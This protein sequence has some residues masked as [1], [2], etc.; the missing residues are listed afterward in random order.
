MRLKLLV[1]IPVVFILGISSILHAQSAATG[2]PYF[3]QGVHY[4]LD[5]TFED[6]YSSPA[7]SGQGRL[8]YT[9]NS[10]DT[11]HEL[12]FHLYWNLFRSGSY[13]ERAPNRDHSP[14]SKYGRGGIDIKALTVGDGG[15]DSRPV[16]YE[17]DNTIMR[18]FL[19]DPLMPGA[20]R[21]IGFEWHAIFPNY[22]VRSTWGWHDKG[23]RNFATAQWYPQV[24]VY[25]NHGWHPDQYIGMGEFYTD[26]G[27]FDVS[28]KMPERFST[29]VS[30]GFQTNAKDILPDSVNQHLDFAHAHP[31][32]IVHISDR[33][34]FQNTPIKKGEPTRTWKFHADSVRDFAWCADEAYIWDAVFDGGVMHHA[35]YWNSSHE[36]WSK[37]AAKIVLVTE[38]TNSEFAGKYAYPNMFLCE[39]YEGGMEYPGIVFVGPS[40]NESTYHWQHNTMMHELGHEWYPMMMG[41]NETDY[42]Y[43]DEG[44]NTFI[45]T[46]VQ[47]KYFGR[48][49]NSF[50]P[51]LG[52]NDDERTAN[53]RNA[54]MHQLI[55][56]QEPSEQKAD[57]YLSYRDY[58]E[59]TYP[60]TSSVFFMLRYTMGEKAFDDFMHLYYQRWRFKHPYPDDLL[61]AAEDIERTEGDT[62]R[63][64]ARGDLRWFFDEWFNK[65]WKLDYAVEDFHVSDTLMVV[66]S[67]GDPVIPIMQTV[68]IAKVTIARK[69]R[70]VMP[71]DLV[72]TFDDG[73]TEQRWIPVDDWLR[74][75]ADERT[76]TYTFAKHPTRVEINPSRELKE[77]NR[78]NNT[79]SWLPPMEVGLIPKVFGDVKPIDKYAIRSAPYVWPLSG[80]FSSG[81]LLGWTFL[82]SYLDRTDRIAIGP[83]VSLNHFDHI[84]NGAAL[85]YHTVLD[86]LSPQTDLDL[87][88]AP[89]DYPQK[90]GFQY[91]GFQ[92]SYLVNRPGTTEPIDIFEGG[93]DVSGAHLI[94]QDVIALPPLNRGHVGYSVSAS[95]PT[96][97]VTIAAQFEDGLGDPRNTYTKIAGLLIDRQRITSDWSALA[98]LFGGSEQ[99]AGGSIPAQT[100]FQLA[101]PSDLDHFTDLYGSNFGSGVRDKIRNATVS[102]PL[103]R[104]Y[105]GRGNDIG[106]AA[107]SGT[108]EIS[109]YSMFPFSLLREI[110]IVGNIFKPFGLVLFADAGV[111]SN[112]VNANNLHDELKSDLGI[113]L[114]WEGL[115]GRM[116]RALDID[117]E[118]A[119]FQID[120][121][122]Y[123]DKPPV[124]ESKL[125]FRVV[126]MVRQ[127]F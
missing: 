105:V 45:T 126:G 64:R 33:S 69:Q 49:N 89:A 54:L 74:T 87:L 79:S 50:G 46:F 44:F 38:Q 22:G 21:K 26:Y 4:T 83:R 24:C 68:F 52:F 84:L 40:E 3:Q 72:F 121:P 16:R 60:H 98:R 5:A 90:Y 39:T 124:G 17:I 117:L 66:A 20:T 12:Y 63:V 86:C 80:D 48:W 104:G 108:F 110:P 8:L 67:G 13:G 35:V 120:F 91:L 103:V 127:D 62:N 85:Q 47:E 78:L 37:E 27:S 32:S 125:A 10:L 58:A 118:R 30:T 101:S 115:F 31:D 11:L 53:Y 95:G 93:V 7:L 29:V 9:N 28:L 123:L 109:N 111:V 56:N 14:D 36:F 106:R 112:D 65:T 57:A 2:I 92:F 15:K 116:E 59:A 114:R 76:Y 119:N 61:N 102:G 71:L 77:T 19:N 96:N 70:C 43:M 100:M 51:G 55:G 99:P 18:V 94:G 23:A 97:H 1:S 88:L 41:S 122:I 42:G 25:D 107:A 6:D 73:T 113:G 81:W 75:V 82:G 34:S